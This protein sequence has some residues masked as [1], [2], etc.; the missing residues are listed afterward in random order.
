ME[1]LRLSGILGIP[2]EK[3]GKPVELLQCIVKSFTVFIATCKRRFMR[4]A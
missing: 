1:Q 4:V 3:R 2:E